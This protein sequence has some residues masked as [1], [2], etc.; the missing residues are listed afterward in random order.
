MM[1]VV[2]KNVYLTYRVIFNY[3]NVCL[4]A[5][6]I[7]LDGA[8]T[9]LT[10]NKYYYIPMH[11]IKFRTLYINDWNENSRHPTHFAKMVK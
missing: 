11:N 10:I 9:K 4:I 2:N 6:I 3:D 1:C 8:V 5:S 7:I